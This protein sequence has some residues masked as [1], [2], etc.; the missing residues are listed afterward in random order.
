VASLNSP[1]KG[2]EGVSG[3][4]YFNKDGDTMKPLVVAVVRDGKFVPYEKQADALA[5]AKKALAAAPPAPATA[6]VPEG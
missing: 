6:E 1:E 3:L 4:T 5:A 2:Y